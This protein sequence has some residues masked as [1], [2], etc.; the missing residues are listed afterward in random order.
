MV[1]KI[2]QL[3]LVGGGGGGEVIST[4]SILPLSNFRAKTVGI[5]EQFFHGQM[6]QG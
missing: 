2:G 1:T 4:P 3:L 6:S 5:L